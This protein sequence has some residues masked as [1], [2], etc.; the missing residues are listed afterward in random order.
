MAAAT[1]LCA[2]FVSCSQDDF[3]D[4]QSEP[5][6]QGEYPLELTA[7]GL[8]TL[9]VPASAPSARGTADDNWD[10]VQSVAVQVGHVV[11]EYTVATI[12]NSDEVTL[13]SGTPFYWQTSEEVMDITAWHPYSG[14]LRPR[15]VDG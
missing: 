13:T 10:G 14:L 1:L 3:A 11:K 8:Q 2:G 12:G 4:T 7:E 9:S 15:H 6:P 5:L